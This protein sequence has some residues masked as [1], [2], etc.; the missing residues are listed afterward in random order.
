MERVSTVFTQRAVGAPA[1]SGSRGPDV[2]PH[3]PGRG[4]FGGQLRA[5]CLHSQIPWPVD[6]LY[7]CLG[8]KS[9]ALEMY[10]LLSPCPLSCGGI[11]IMKKKKVV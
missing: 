3:I 7:N 2:P 6:T 9:H 1:L 4:D 8:Q 5:L 11:Q 10:L